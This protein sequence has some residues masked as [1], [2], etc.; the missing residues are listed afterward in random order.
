MRL[1]ILQHPI[2]RAV[3][4]ISKLDMDTRTIEPLEYWVTSLRHF[5]VWMK[6]EQFSN[7]CGSRLQEML[8][9]ARQ[10]SSLR[11]IGVLPDT[12]LVQQWLA[13]TMSHCPLNE[14][15]GKPWSYYSPVRVFCWVLESLPL[16]F[17]GGSFEQ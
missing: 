5:C 1:R 2:V 14:V 6:S 7:S 13:C 11:L 17:T 9:L 4:Q 15:L 10:Y 8:L 16:Y 12:V 3:P